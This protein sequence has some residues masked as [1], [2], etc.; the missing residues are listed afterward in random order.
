MRSFSCAVML[1]VFH[2]LLHIISQK[3]L[4]AHERGV[5]HYS[6]GCSYISNYCNSCEQELGENQDIPLVAINCSERNLTDFPTDLPRNTGKLL[7]GYNAITR[8]NLD[9]MKKMRFLKELM[10]EE[11]YISFIHKGSFQDNVMLQTLN[12]GGNK[13]DDLTSGIFKGLRNLL[14]LYLNRNRISR[15]ENGTFENLISLNKLDLS[16]N[17]IFVIDQEA[18]SGL[19]HL[20]YLD[21]ARNKLGIVCQVHFGALTSLQTLNLGFN[22]INSLE[23][24]SFSNLM[25]LKILF[26]DNN[27][28]TFVPKDVFKSLKALAG[29]DLSSNPIEFIPLDIFASLRALKFLNV[30]FSSVRVFHGA[31]LKVILPHLRMYVQQNPLD[32]TCDMLWLKEWLSDDPFQNS[33]FPQWSQVKCKYPNK[34]DG[35]SLLSLNIADLGCSCEYCQ[36]SSMCIPGGKTC[37]CGAN[38]WAV[39]SCFDACQ[40]ND[41]I[42]STSTSTSVRGA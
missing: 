9:E 21:L 38:K 25:H 37:N 36:R 17:E 14:K 8:L 29:L 10:I 31:H 23:V 32:C 2:L 20:T 26:L 34:L 41:T 27:N 16:E 11:N 24:E 35:R 13:L 33:T 5:P 30:S 6:T 3:L 40:L 7:L 22:I 18:F 39:P 19:Q 42:T 15:L 28:L 4:S 12:M 1:L